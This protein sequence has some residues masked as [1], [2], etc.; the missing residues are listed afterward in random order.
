MDEAFLRRI[1]VVIEFPAPDARHRRALWERGLR[2][3]APIGPDLDL[4]LVAE[5]FELTGGEI[6]NCWVDAAHRAA[7]EGGDIGMAELMQAI[8][9]ELSKQGKPLRKSDFG[10]HYAR[11]RGM[12]G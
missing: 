7:C 5:R 10:S 6:R 12:G 11:L 1:D 9:T 2:T 8:G 4:D 3:T